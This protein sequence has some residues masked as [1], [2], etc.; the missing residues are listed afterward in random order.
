MKNLSI[1]FFAVLFIGCASFGAKTA[2]DYLAKSEMYYKTGDLKASWN[3]A[4]KA[5]E[6]DPKAVSAYGIMGTILYDQGKYDEAI[7]YFEVLYQAGDKRSEVISAL[8]A[9]YASKGSYGEALKYVDEALTLNPS[10]LAALATKGGIYYAK[11]QYPQAIDVYTKAIA[12]L[13]SAL[14][15]NARGAAYQKMG[16]VQEALQDYKA[17]GVEVEVIAGEEQAAESK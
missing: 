9:A 6:K 4:Q 7:K 17:A 11:E 3:N 8:A 16:K 2:N 10:N 1:L 13:P 14:L 12:I 5:L 15:Y